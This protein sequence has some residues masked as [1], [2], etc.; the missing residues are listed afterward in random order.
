MAVGTLDDS[1]HV[2]VAAADSLVDRS[3]LDYDHRDNTNQSLEAGG[4]SHCHIDHLVVGPLAGGLTS[5]RWNELLL[6]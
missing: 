3:S 1:H 5:L 6:H 2:V 4:R